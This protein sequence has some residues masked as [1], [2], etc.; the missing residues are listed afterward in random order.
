MAR[1]H[2]S[3]SIPLQPGPFGVTAGPAR[4][5]RPS[6]PNLPLGAPAGF[7]PDP[8]ATDPRARVRPLDKAVDK[9][10]AEPSGFATVLRNRYF[11]RLWIAQ[12][13]SQTIMNAT[14]YGLITLIAKE[15]HSLLSTGVAIVTFALPA[16][17]FGAPAGVVVDHFDRRKVLWASNA[18]R[19]LATLLFIL[20]LKINSSA[21]LPVYALTFLIAVIGQFFG[22]AEGAAIPRLVGRREVIN[23]LALFNITFTISQAAGLIVMGPLVLLLVPQLQVAS[24]GYHLT[25]TPLEFLLLL[26]AALYFVCVLLILTIP[27]NVLEP[28]P[29]E[30]QARLAKLTKNGKQFRAVLGGIGESLGFIG[31]RPRLSVVVFQLSLAGVVTSVIAMIAPKFVTLYFGQPPEAAALV[32]VPAGIGLVVGAVFTPNIARRLRYGKTVFIGIVALA[33]ATGA[34]T[35]AHVLDGYLEAQGWPVTIPFRATVLVLTFLMGFALDFINVPA[36]AMMQELS[37]DYIKGRVLAVQI[38]FF[39]AITIPVVLVLGR[40]GDA[41]GLDYAI[42]ALAIA[43]AVVG[44]FSVLLWMIAQAV[45]DMR[46]RGRPETASRPITYL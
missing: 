43:V 13:I 31:K 6:L 36:Q 25:I 28:N 24:M 23:A 8:H 42:N 33:L 17:L 9:A 37:P 32:F 1:T 22:P 10:E 7:G 27:H 41:V 2:R 16:L 44:G 26:V 3:D 34:I 46:H 40:V 21:L 4:E 39:N 12:V 5:R 30:S 38:M 20:S 14:N 11:L 35:T 45:Y 18:L 19:A 29:A 15:S